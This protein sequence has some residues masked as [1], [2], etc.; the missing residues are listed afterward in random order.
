MLECTTHIAMITSLSRLPSTLAIVFKIYP[1]FSQ[2]TNNSYGISIAADILNK[3]S[4]P[5][6][7]PY[8]TKQSFS[9]F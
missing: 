2:E 7:K 8:S 5:I 6:A 4:D 9:K 3:G 1:A